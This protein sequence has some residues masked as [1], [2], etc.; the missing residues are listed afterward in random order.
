MTTKMKRYCVKEI[1]Y[2]INI[3]VGIRHHKDVVFT[4]FQIND[5]N[6]GNVNADVALISEE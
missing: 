2:Q 4:R 5:K 3:I 1:H 6:I